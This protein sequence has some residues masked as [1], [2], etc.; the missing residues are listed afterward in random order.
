MKFSMLLFATVLFSAGC[1]TTQEV[2][3]SAA[4]QN[5]KME[6]AYLV[7]HGGNSA[8]MDNHIQN[9]LQAHGVK[10]Q[11]GPDNMRSDTDLLV[12]YTDRWRWDLVMYLE[13][14]HITF[15][16]GKTGNLLGTGMWQNS[17][18]HKFRGADVVVKSVM[19]EMFAKS[20]S[21]KM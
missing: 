21:P 19:N 9:E 4:A 13:D 11:T 2:T 6:T 17:A 15:F 14:V 12:K 3:M 10:V 16:E 8:D 18:W 7:S 5:S 1:A 20:K